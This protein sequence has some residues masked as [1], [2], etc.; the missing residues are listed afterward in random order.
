M[1]ENVDAASRSRM[2]GR[3]TGLGQLM[4][5]HRRG[6]GNRAKMQIKELPRVKGDIGGA[7]E[8]AEIDCLV[9]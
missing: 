7:T 8:G 6:R 3:G 9:T 1:Q 5:V 4:I 2:R